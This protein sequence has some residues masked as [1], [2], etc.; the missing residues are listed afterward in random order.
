MAPAP[1][2]EPEKHGAYRKAGY[3]PLESLEADDSPPPPRW[4]LPAVMITVLTVGGWFIIQNLWA[5]SKL[6]DCTMSGRKNCVAPIDTS[7][8]VK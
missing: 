2:E 5:T 8:M 7:Q 6:E 1:D 3:T 4:I